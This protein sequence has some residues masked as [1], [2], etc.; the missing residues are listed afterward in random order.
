[1]ILRNY[2]L[3]DIQHVDMFDYGPL[4][5]FNLNIMTLLIHSG[6]STKNDTSIQNNKNC[7]HLMNIL[8]FIKNDP[9]KI[10]DPLLK[11]RPNIFLT[12]FFQTMHLKVDAVGLKYY[13]IRSPMFIHHENFPITKIEL[14]NTERTIVTVIKNINH[15]YKFETTFFE[16]FWYKVCPLKYGC[17]K[18]HMFKRVLVC[19]E[20]TSK[21]SNYLKYWYVIVIILCFLS[22]LLEMY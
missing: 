21:I 17:Y 3:N 19:N 5:R 18:E 9:I 20:Q 1:M 2:S 12:R 15:D 4:I 10:D 8:K 22:K 6:R 16:D 7:N 11:T 14:E 13:G